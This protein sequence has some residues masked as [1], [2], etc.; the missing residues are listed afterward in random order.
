MTREHQ[1]DAIEGGGPVDRTSR[2]PRRKSRRGVRVALVAVISLAL[3]IVGAGAAYLGLLNHT[4]NTNITHDRLIP[5]P[6][7]TILD[8][9]GEPVLGDD[10]TPVQA[11]PPPEPA[12]EAGEA[13]NILILGSD[14][15]DLSVE[16]GRS[17][18]IV[19]M[20]ISDDRES[21]HL[22]HVPRDFFV[23]IPG[24]SRKNK[25]NAA[26]AHG[27]APLTAQTLQPV[28][29]V[30]V[31]HVVMVNF[32]SFK[33]MTDAVGGV[34]V[35]VA[36]ASP[37]FP[38]GTMHMDGETGLEFVRERMTLSQGDITRGQRQQAFIKA[39]MLKALSRETLTNPVRL[40]NFVDA[41][42]T[43]LVVD[44]ALEVGVMRDVGFSMRGV[45]GNDITFVTAPWSG[46]GM[47]D[48][49]GSIVIPHEQQLERLRHHL[50]TDTM[51]EYVDEVSPRS[52]WG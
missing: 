44:E 42:T 36:E 20:H 14:S 47:D 4:V 50:R 19:L 8:E 23:E 7:E 40:A 16:R 25:I 15:R 2:A 24:Q 12:P 22:V 10:G 39:V 37:G 28:L 49:A 9:Q 21:V 6:G 38:V 13:L 18:V 29:G 41:A 33:E 3:L 46:I 31:D 52:G 43:N 17:D 5:E 26:Y 51:D 1:A 11:T 48:W 35:E 45:R 32:D 30:A 34:D 27:G